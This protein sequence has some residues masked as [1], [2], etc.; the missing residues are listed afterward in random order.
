MVDRVLWLTPGHYLI[1]VVVE[2]DGGKE[3]S[4]QGVSVEVELPAYAQQV[5]EFGTHDTLSATGS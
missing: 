4:S 3:K 5:R 2:D 1:E